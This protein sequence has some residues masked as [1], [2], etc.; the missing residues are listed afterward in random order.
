MIDIARRM[1][2]D[3]DQLI[4]SDV[5]RASAHPKRPDHRVPPT[6][7]VR[8]SSLV[9][10]GGPGRPAPEPA[11]ARVAARCPTVLPVY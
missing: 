5:I 3:P 11:R 8:D 1:R 6:D 9:D 2:W 7:A 4:D 10:A